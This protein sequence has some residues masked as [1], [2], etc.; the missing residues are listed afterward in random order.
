RVPREEGTGL[1]GEVRTRA[2]EQ[3]AI[4]S[5]RVQGL[6]PATAMTETR[7]RLFPEPSEAI[8]VRARPVPCRA[9]RRTHRPA[10]AQVLPRRARRPPD[11]RA[12]GTAER[13]LHPAAGARRPG[14]LPQPGGHGALDGAARTRAD[15]AR[16]DHH[17]TGAV[18]AAARG[19]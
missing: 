12:R 6:N 8:D 9:G 3:R 2:P 17:G 18:A 7:R 11:H 15:A 10:A 14:D 13:L 19:G 16:E 5:L 4:I 1:R